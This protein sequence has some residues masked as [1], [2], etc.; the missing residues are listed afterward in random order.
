[1]I[2][3]SSLFFFILLFEGTL[4]E[5]EEKMKLLVANTEKTNTMLHKNNKPMVESH[6]TDVVIK[7]K[8]AALKQKDFELEMT[9]QELNSTK[10][11]MLEQERLIENYIEENKKLK[12][13]L[14]EASKEKSNINEIKSMF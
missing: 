3:N 6:Q 2:K 11:K 7:Q 8:D 14:E 10:M 1:M 4:L 9:K 5:C 13:A 12:L